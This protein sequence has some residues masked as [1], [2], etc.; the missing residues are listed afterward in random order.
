MPE[1]S[2]DDHERRVA[3]DRAALAESLDRLGDTLAPETAQGGSL[4]GREGIR[5]RDKTPA[6]GSRAGKIRRPSP[7]SARGL[8]CFSVAEDGVPRTMSCRR[9]A[10]KRAPL[11]PPCRLPERK[12][13]RCA[14]PVATTAVGAPAPGT[15]D[16]LSERVSTGFRQKARARVREARLAAIRAQEDVERRASRLAARAD[17][18]V[19]DR[20]VTA[21]ATAFGIGA[22]LAA[23]LPATRR[24]DE[25]MGA[26]RDR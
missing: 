9:A 8:R 21:T 7:S 25:I 15:S 14:R 10:T 12:S 6:L 24:E 13:P 22:L 3:E 20:P 17:R 23:F 2:L 11:G 1:A 4:I 18:A 16:P 26:R 5:R 19:H